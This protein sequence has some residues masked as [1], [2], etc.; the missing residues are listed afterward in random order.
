MGIREKVGGQLHSSVF[1]LFAV[2]A[3]ARTECLSAAK[4][5][6]SACA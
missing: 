3:A 5:L 2:F 4:S 6:I 1:Y